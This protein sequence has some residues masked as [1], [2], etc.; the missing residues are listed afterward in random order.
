MLVAAL[1]AAGAAPSARAD[2]VTIFAAASLSEVLKEVA[3]AY[4]LQT[5]DQLVFNFASSGTLARQ[6]EAGAPADIFFSADEARMDAVEKKGLLLPGTRQSRLSNA[7]VIVVPSDSTLGLKSPQDLA[8]P[9]V[10][11]IALGNPRTVPAG[12]YARAYLTSLDLW[13][14]VEPK[15]VPTENVRAALAAVEAGNA[16][17]SII[18]KTDVAIAKKVTVIFE[19][20]LGTGPKICYPMALVAD[21]KRAAAARRCLKY[22]SGEEAGRIF[23]AHGFILLEPAK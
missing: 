12:N 20:S 22:L 13:A 4:E 9:K 1:L 5:G 10:G 11:R 23:K 14:K 8:D 6:I 7:L 17:A 19:V 21:T 18:Y 2:R 3:T 15:V 16:D